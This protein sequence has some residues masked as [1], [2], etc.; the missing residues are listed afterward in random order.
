[1]ELPHSRVQKHLK[2]RVEKKPFR[3]DGSL[4]GGRYQT[5]WGILQPGVEDSGTLVKTKTGE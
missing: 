4:L 5:A 3:L 1:M 2:R